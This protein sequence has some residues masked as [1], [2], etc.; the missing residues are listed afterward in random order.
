[1]ES[2]IRDLEQTEA[3]ATLE[4]DTAALRK[5]WANDFT[6]NAPTGRVVTG[7]KSTLDRPVITQN[8]Y[9]SFTR[10]V[11]HIFIKGDFVFAM[12]NELVIPKGNDGKP[13]APIKRRYTN[14]WMSE[15]GSWRLVARHAN[16][17][18]Q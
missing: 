11:E 17:I 6:V 5:L 2:T 15:T 4:K 1:M 14:I 18:C 13:G 3:K 16:V 9:V 10:T 8:N 12:G 7:G